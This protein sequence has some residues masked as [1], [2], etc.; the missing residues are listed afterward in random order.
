MTEEIT[1]VLQADNLINPNNAPLS[2]NGGT[3]GTIA[4]YQAFG[5][6]AFRCVVVDCN[7]FQTSSI[8]TDWLVLPSS[9][10]LGALIISTNLGN[11]QSFSIANEGVTQNVAIVTSLAGSG[12]NG[13]M[14][15]HFFGNTICSVRGPFNEIMGNAGGAGP[16]NG[17]I[18]IIGI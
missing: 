14:Q 1:D 2:E 6:S 3:S 9:F 13:V 15:D 17:Q 12:G 11:K 4:L 16:A 18:I 8:G 10:S 7:N 5:G